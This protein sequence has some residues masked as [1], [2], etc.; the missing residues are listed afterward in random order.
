MWM[1]CDSSKFSYIELV[2]RNI[3][4]ST[5]GMFVWICQDQNIKQWYKYD[6]FVIS[7]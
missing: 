2:T 6:I 5:G 7:A 1:N 3:F 4:I